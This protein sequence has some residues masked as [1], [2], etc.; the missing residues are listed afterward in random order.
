[1]TSGF[2][3]HLH[4]QDYLAT[5]F[6]TRGREVT[7]RLSVPVTLENTQIAGHSFDKSQGHK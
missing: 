6:R 7:G 5:H 3:P 4:P 1:M 2:Y